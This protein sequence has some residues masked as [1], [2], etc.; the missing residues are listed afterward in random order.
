MSQTLFLF[1]NLFAV[2]LTGLNKIW[3]EQ[4]VSVREGAY[5]VRILERKTENADFEAL[6]D[7]KGVETAK[8][9]IQSADP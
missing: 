1:I 6:F 4:S 2:F 5:G 9:W 7:H 8:G 3:H